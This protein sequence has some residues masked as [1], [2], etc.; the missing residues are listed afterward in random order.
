MSFGRFYGESS[1]SFFK[2]YH[3]DEKCKFAK[4]KILRRNKNESA[5]R[6]A[7]LILFFFSQLETMN[8]VL[9]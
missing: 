8:S 6:E 5:G 2:G 9:M 4:K 1:I 7:R 3:V